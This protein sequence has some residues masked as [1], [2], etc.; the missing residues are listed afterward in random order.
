MISEDGL[1]AQRETMVRQQLAARGIHDERVLAAMRAVPRHAFVPR[2]EIPYAYEDRPLRIGKGQTISQPY[3]VALM[4]QLLELQ[5]HEKVLE[6]GTGSGYQ[7]AILGGMAAEVHTIERHVEL[8]EGAELI[9]ASMGIKNVHVH[10]GDGSL[11]WPDAAYY[12]AIVATASAPKAPQAVLEQLATGGR[13][14][15]PVGDARRQ[16]LQRWLRTADG[17]EFED[18]IPVAFVPLIGEQGWDLH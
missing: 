13:L 10:I 2:R 17:L 12:D 8:A 7:A 6:I 1:A 16:L 4:T 18:M 11:G 15:L 14:V 9:L 3:M 5:G